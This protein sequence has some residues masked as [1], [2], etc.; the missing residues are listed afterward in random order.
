MVNEN[1]QACRDL[2]T[3]GNATELDEGGVAALLLRNFDMYYPTKVPFLINI[4]IGLFKLDTSG[5]FIKGTNIFLDDVSSLDDVWIVGLHQAVAWMKSPRRTGETEAL[6]AWGCQTHLLDRCTV[7]GLDESEMNKASN[8]TTD[9]EY[10]NTIKGLFPDGKVLVL[11]QTIILIA[12]Y[13]AIWHYDKVTI[14][15]K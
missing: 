4:D 7:M 5:N 3:C 8:A 1:G 14:K 10:K 2:T 13:L 11:W 9:D 6:P 15:K 12:L